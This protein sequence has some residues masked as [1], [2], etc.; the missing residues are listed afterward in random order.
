MKAQELKRI[1]RFALFGAIG[2]GIGGAVAGGIQQAISSPQEM[3]GSFV[4]FITIPIW[5]AIA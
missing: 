5:G 3:F 4:V 2:F 1:G